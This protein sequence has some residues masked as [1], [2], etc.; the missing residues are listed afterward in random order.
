MS[1]NLSLQCTCFLTQ[2]MIEMR[3]MQLHTWIAL[4]RPFRQCSKGLAVET[5]RLRSRGIEGSQ[6]VEHL[7]MLLHAAL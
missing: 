1:H 2:L 7:E 4:Q 6:T 3:D 5:E